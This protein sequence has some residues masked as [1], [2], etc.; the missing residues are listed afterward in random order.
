M[1]GNIPNRVAV[2][3]TTKEMD[4]DELK[5]LAQKELEAMGIRSFYPI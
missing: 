3:K 5:Q 1:Q 4:T 2:E